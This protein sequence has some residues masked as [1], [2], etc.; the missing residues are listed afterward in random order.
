MCLSFLEGAL[1]NTHTCTVL[2]PVLA[3]LAEWSNLQVSMHF[4]C[5]NKATWIWA[6]ASVFLYST[7]Y[8]EVALHLGVFYSTLWAP[9]QQILKAV[10]CNF[11]CVI[12]CTVVSSN[13]GKYLNFLLLLCLQ[14]HW[15]G[16]AYIHVHMYALMCL[17]F[18][19]KNPGLLCCS[20]IYQLSMTRTGRIFFIDIMVKDSGVFLVFMLTTLCNP[21]QS[22]VYMGPS[23]QFVDIFSQI[24]FISSVS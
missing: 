7:S 5:F 23:W 12:H 24:Q 8:C 17:W 21:L 20:F 22:R 14:W 18:L 19:Q 6:N 9:M 2:I 15:K 4:Y 1:S 16:R 10:F 13:L 3:S 11:I